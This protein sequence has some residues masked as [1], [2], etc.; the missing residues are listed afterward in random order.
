MGVRINAVAAG[1]L[2]LGAA[3]AVDPAGLAPFGPARWLWISTLATLTIGLTMWRRSGARSHR[4]TVDQRAVVTCR[5]LLGMSE[6]E[7]AAALRIRPGTVKSRLHR[8][9]Q[10]LQSLLRP[11]HQAT[12][13]LPQENDH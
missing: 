7:T 6:A 13:D 5:L 12:Q 1:A 8:A 10:R 3:A 4:L 11:L 2:V 9:T